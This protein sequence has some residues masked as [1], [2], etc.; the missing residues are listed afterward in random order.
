MLLLPLFEKIVSELGISAL[1]LA[2]YKRELSLHAC[3]HVPLVAETVEME[4]KE[5]Q[6]PEIK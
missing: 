2:S 4:G 1:Q 6:P 5:A 3:V